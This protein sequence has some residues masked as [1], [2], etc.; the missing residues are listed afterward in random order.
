MFRKTLRQ[1]KKREREKNRETG[2]CHN[3]VPFGGKTFSE[4]FKSYGQLFL[5]FPL[6]KPPTMRRHDK[7]LYNIQQ[8]KHKYKLILS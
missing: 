1:K 7:K 6:S 5:H 2:S 8:A 4:N 3:D